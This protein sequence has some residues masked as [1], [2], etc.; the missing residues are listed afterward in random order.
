MAAAMNLYCLGTLMGFKPSATLLAYNQINPD[1]DKFRFPLQ[2]PEDLI[3]YAGRWD[4]GAKSLTKFGD[5]GI[6]QRWMSQGEESMIEMGD[7]T[8][9]IVCS[10]VVSH[11]L[12]RHRLASFQQESQRFVSYEDEEF[13]DIFYIPNDEFQLNYGLERSLEAYKN[14]KRSGTA[15]QLAR[16]VLPNATRTRMVMKANFREW[17]HILK[18]R[19]HSSAQPEMQIVANQIHDQL[20]EK[21]PIIFGDIKASLEAGERA[22]R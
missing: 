7:A 6:I 2:D 14:L 4:Y 19:M 10:R 8:F 13:D 16:Y 15:K 11:E 12:V 5:R 20:V 18:L 3:E 1:L 17:R 21:F 9:F 22:A